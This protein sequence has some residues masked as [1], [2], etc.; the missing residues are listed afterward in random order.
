MRTNPRPDGTAVALLLA[1]LCLAVDCFG[2]C[3]AGNPKLTSKA[4]PDTRALPWV[5][6]PDAV[7]AA[8]REFLA[9]LEGATP[10]SAARP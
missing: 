4:I 3:G 6:R 1:A 8:I 9:G 10:S 7:V 5:D 2:G